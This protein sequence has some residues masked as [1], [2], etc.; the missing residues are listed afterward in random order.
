MSFP[1]SYPET[2]D[3]TEGELREMLDAR[4][5]EKDL[6]RKKQGRKL[7]T[8][9]IVFAIVLA[10]S[11]LCFPGR[12]NVVHSVVT[13]N[14]ETAAA[15]KAVLNAQKNPS[16]SGVSDELKPFSVKPGESDHTADIR[17]AV[18]LLQFMQPPAHEPE[19]GAKAIP[20]EPVTRGKQ[21]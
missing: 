1:E 10:G 5:L 19:K 17:F 18:E 20:A 14:P 15:I 16:A 7:T 4:E 9:L 2:K 13:E 11:I 12:R 3:P 8:F 6:R 21:P